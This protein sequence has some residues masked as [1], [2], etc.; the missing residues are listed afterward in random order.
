VDRYQGLKLLGH[1]DLNGFG[2]GGEGIAV[3]LLKQGRRVA[4]IAH[5][6][7]PKDLSIVDVTDPRSPRVLLQTDLPHGDVRSNSLAL[8]GDTLLV[9]Y[10][11]A[12]T[13]L[14]PAGVGI[15]DVADPEK[16]KR[17]GFFDTSGPHS[18]GCHCLWFVDGRYAH[19]S[20]GMPDFT[21]THSRDDQI[22]VILDVRD[23]GRPREAGRWWLPGTRQGDNVPSPKRHARFDHGFRAH[24]TNV[25][26]ARPNRAYV[27]YLDAGAVILDIS[28]M[29]RPALISRVDHHPPFAGFTHTVLPLFGRD[30]LVVTDEALT[31]NCEDWPKLVWV[32]DSWTSESIVVGSFFA[33]GIR[34]YDIGDPFRPREVAWYVPDAPPGCPSIQTND[35]YVDERGVIYAID[36]IKGGLHILE[37]AF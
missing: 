2:N 29:L 22:Y 11:V 37:M 34:V 33:G 36:R 32:M 1:S 25:Y 7:G 3:K 17:I 4:F 19:L 28:D 30:L 24:N 8:V 10:Q 5:E 20:T 35:V 14:Q 13:G 18:R 21:P 12:R 26:P 16:P 9:A 31:N 6:S 15:Y 27:G 23:P